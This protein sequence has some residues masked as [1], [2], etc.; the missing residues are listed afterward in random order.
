MIQKEFACLLLPQNSVF[1]P[2]LVVGDLKL[3]NFRQSDGIE[4]TAHLAPGVIPEDDAPFLEQASDGLGD[5]VTHLPCRP[6]P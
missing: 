3:G 4:L 1:Q 6:I 2:E 5:A